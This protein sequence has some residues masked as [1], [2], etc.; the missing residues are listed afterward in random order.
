VARRG[1]VVAFAEQ[2]GDQV[3][4][5]DLSDIVGETPFESLGEAVARH[6]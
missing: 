1:G 2:D 5:I 6:T 4:V 3:L